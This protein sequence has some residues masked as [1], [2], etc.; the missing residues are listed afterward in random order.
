MGWLTK[1][2]EDAEALRALVKAGKRGKDPGIITKEE[3]N[4]E[5]LKLHGT[6]LYPYQ[7]PKRRKLEKQPAKKRKR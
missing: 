5:F 2:L 7:K 1:A 4:K 3:A 6:S